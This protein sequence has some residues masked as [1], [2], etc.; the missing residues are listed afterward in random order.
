MLEEFSAAKIDATQTDGASGADRPA[1][2]AGAGA[3]G[4][5]SSEPNLEDVLSDDDFAKKLQAEMAE[6]MGGLGN[7]PEMATQFDKIFKEIAAAAGEIDETA[8]PSTAGSTEKPAADAAASDASFQE[9]I[10]RTMERM[11]TSGDQATA[12]ATEAGTDD[13]MAEMLK[14]LG[15]GGLEGL[16]GGEEE[17]SKMLLGMME[18]LTNK[19]IL[20]EPMKELNEKFPEW[21]EK[22]KDKTPAEDLKRYEEQ[23]VLC[24]EI[25]AKFEEKSYSDSN[26]ADREYIV[27]RMQKVSMTD[28][29]PDIVR[30][31]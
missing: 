15:S 2:S 3:A 30:F 14:S 18:Q 24:K 21:M 8:G 6:M 26:S 27:D 4:A 9:T 20:Y 23:Q 11:Q 17:F 25:V 7:D 22:N 5:S 31:S 29:N 16:Q 19:D 1:S 12:A 28:Q 10:R 13:L